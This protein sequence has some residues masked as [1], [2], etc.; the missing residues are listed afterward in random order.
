MKIVNDFASFY[1]FSIGYWNIF[2]Q[3]GIFCV[4]FNQ[5]NFQNFDSVQTQISSGAQLVL[6]GMPIGC[7]CTKVDNGQLRCKK[8][9][10]IW[11]IMPAYVF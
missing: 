11:I 1:D 5:Y 6:L 10:N 7:W 3:C 4:S 2:W 9:S 8:K